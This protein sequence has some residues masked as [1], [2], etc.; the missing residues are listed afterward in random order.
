MEDRSE[1]DTEESEAREVRQDHGV[2]RTTTTG[3]PA[4]DIREP[5]AGAVEDDEDPGPGHDE[6]VRGTGE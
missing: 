5:G 4:T 6:D 1:S 3:D 2:P